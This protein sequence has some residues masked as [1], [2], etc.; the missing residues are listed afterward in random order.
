MKAGFTPPAWRMAKIAA[1]RAYR[2]WHTH[3]K[4]GRFMSNWR[5]ACHNVSFIDKN[6]TYC[7]LLMRFCQLSLMYVN[8][9]PYS[10][11]FGPKVLARYAI[12]KY[13]CSVEKTKRITNKN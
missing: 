4:N 8:K 2:R 7:T 12:S 11:T 3:R 6:M 10:A 1:Q 13:L 5:L 9:S